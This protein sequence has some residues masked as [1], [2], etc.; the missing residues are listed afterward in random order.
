VG[1]FT[2]SHQFTQPI[3]TFGCEGLFFLWGID[4]GQANLV[5]FI[6]RVQIGNGVVVSYAHGFSMQFVGEDD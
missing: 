2:A 5:L 6:V 3:F 1:N 4:T